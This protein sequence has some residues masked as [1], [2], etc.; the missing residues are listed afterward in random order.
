MC[1]V[2][3]KEAASPKT[4]DHEADHHTQNCLFKIVLCCYYT[5]TYMKLISHNQ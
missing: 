2:I 3:N 5:L 4:A 1:Q